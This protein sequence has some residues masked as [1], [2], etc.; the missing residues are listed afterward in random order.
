MSEP[1]K[2]P[3]QRGYALTEILIATAI[4][5][6]VLTAIASAL[7]GVVRLNA[8]S[9]ERAQQLTD[10][11]TIVARLNAGLA[12]D[13]ILAGLTGWRIE[14]APLSLG[15]TSDAS[16]TFDIVIVRNDTS[17]VRSFEFLARRPVG[18]R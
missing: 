18:G 6:G 12:G 2:K 11:K 9:E 10:V 17:A 15:D 1:A 5:A 7:S 13:D 3:R 16:S 14:R 8:R 4:A